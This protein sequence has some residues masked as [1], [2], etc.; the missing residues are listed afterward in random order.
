M[1]ATT[2]GSWACSAGRWESPE[3]SNRRS[4]RG[5]RRQRKP[6][7]DEAR[8]ERVRYVPGRALAGIIPPYL[9][10]QGSIMTDTTNTTSTTGAAAAGSTAGL[11]FIRAIVTE[12]LRNGVY[13]TIVTRFPPEPNG[14]LHIGHA[15]AI[16]VDFGVAQETGGRCNLRFDDTNPETEDMMYVDSAVEMIRWLGYEPSAILFAS[17]YFPQ[18]YAFAEHLI[19]TGHAYVDSLN[20][21]EIREYRGTVTEP[22]RNSPYRDRSVEENLDLFRRM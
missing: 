20:E 2:R 1:K 16:S 8:G 7:A 18:M 13:T 6:R 15:K 14:Y 12:D 19:K 22:G 4:C 17:D 9:I 21:E 11:D 3:R 5:R 10:H